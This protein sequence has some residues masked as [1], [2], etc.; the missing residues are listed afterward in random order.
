MQAVGEHLIVRIPPKKQVTDSGII[1]GVI[2]QRRM[3]GRIVSIGHTA[4]PFLGPVEDGT[5]VV[6]DPQ[7]VSPL[8]VDPTDST[9]VLL[10]MNYS[11]VYAT[12]TE[13]ELAELG[14]PL[15]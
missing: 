12:M 2:D 3:Y 14:V 8:N 6:F 10:A 13:Q 7:G 15:A 4:K 5:H 1:V 9:P 11:N